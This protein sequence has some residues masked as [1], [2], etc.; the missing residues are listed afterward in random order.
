MK[1]IN[2]HF[3][4]NMAPYRNPQLSPALTE[5]LKRKIIGQTRLRQTN[6]DDADY[7]V[8]ATVTDYSVSTS[9]V[10]DRKKSLN[11]LNVTVHI[12]LLNQRS[13]TPEE[14]DVNWKVDF[15]ANLSLQA[16]ESQVFDTMIRSLSDD[17]FNRM[18]SNW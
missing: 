8:K 2:V 7:D 15:D 12:A 14:Y 9:G 4:E 18:F 16:A 17:I 5:R 10:T 1:T 13:N 11:R 6:S 3:I